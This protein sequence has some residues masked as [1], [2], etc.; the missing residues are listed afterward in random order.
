MQLETYNKFPWSQVVPA[1]GTQF[2]GAY[3]RLLCSNLKH[4]KFVINNNTTRSIYL[5]LFNYPVDCILFYVCE[6][7]MGS[8]RGA[9]PQMG[10]CPS[11][12][13]P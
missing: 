2:V 3:L 4:S 10:A 7:Q 13:P 1:A 12:H 11:L 6:T 8:Q 9:N 5:L